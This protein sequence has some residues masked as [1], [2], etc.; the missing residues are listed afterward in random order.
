MRRK[1]PGAWGRAH[2]DNL[3]DDVGTL[4]TSARKSDGLDNLSTGGHSDSLGDLLAGDS[5]GLGN[6]VGQGLGDSLSASGNGVN[7]NG[8]VGSDLVGDGVCD[9]LVAN[10]SGLLATRNNSGLGSGLRSLGGSLRSLRRGLHSSSLGSR[11]SD[12]TGSGRDT[13]CD[14]HGGEADL[15]VRLGH[16]NDNDTGLSSSDNS[17]SLLAGINTESGRNLGGRGSLDNRHG[18]NGSCRGLSIRDN[19]GLSVSGVDNSAGA[20]GNTVG[21]GHGGDGNLAVGLGHGDSCDNLGDLRSLRGGDTQS[22][23]ASDITSRGG[24]GIGSLN[25]GGS[26]VSGSRGLNDGS[27]IGDN[28]RLRDSEGAG[29][30]DNVTTNSRLVILASSNRSVRRKDDGGGLSGLLHVTSRGLGSRRGISAADLELLLAVGNGIVLSSALSTSLGLL[31]TSIVKSL[32][33]LSEG[34]LVGT[35]TDNEIVLVAT[36]HRRAGSTN[37]DGAVEDG[38]L[39]DDNDDRLVDLADNS[40]A[41]SNLRSSGELIDSSGVDDSRGSHS[42]VRER[43]GLGDDSVLAVASG[44]DDARDDGSEDRGLSLSAGSGLIGS[45]VGSLSVVLNSGGLGSSSSSDSGLLLGSLRGGNTEGFGSLE[46]GTSGGLLSSLGGCSLGVL[47]TS[48]L[49]AG[50][51][52]GLVNEDGST[53]GDGLESSFL[54]RC[55]LSQSITTSSD[56]ALDGS[57]RG[58]LSTSLSLGLLASSTLGARNGDGLVD[59]DGSTVGDV[60]SR[61]DSHLGSLVGNLTSVG[62]DDSA[63]NLK[64]RGSLGIGFTSSASCA[65]GARDGHSLV[66][67]D[68]STVGDVRGRDDGDLR[69]RNIGNRRKKT[70]DAA[71]NASLLSNNKQHLEFCSASTKVPSVNC[72]MGL[73]GVRFSTGILDIDRG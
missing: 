37:D 40:A 33:D 69:L 62:G 5:D 21:E 14:G 61:N 47:A 3:G 59:K 10:D 52:D 46:V 64:L 25:S 24:L 41:G 1:R 15:A 11:N 67:K 42:G 73:G 43:T 51:G 72:D 13:S 71:A 6:L 36:L 57:L 9:S 7:T 50:D 29:R 23:R 38:N 30:D 70:R 55:A 63:D 16:G 17:G 20:S 4:L 49:G 45:G 54:R 39:T 60:R 28:T 34:L 2:G 22:G 58:L 48:T 53:V 19:L 27:T 65:P 35:G 56:L 18:L 44:E 31:A 8:D 12:N 66:D 32:I 68:S 26:G